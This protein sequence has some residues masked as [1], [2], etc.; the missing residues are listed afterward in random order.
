MAKQKSKLLT[1]LSKLVISSQEA[2]S[3]GKQLTALEKYLHVDRKIQIDLINQMGK[4]SKEG[5]KHLIFLTGSSGDGKS[6]LFSIIDKKQ[7]ELS[8]KFL[9][10]YD[11]TA[12][13]RPDLNSIETLIKDLDSFSDEKINTYSNDNSFVILAINLGVLN[14]FISNR[15]V[16]KK[17]SELIKFVDN[18]K[19]YS[20]GKITRVIESNEN[21]LFSI[22]NFTGYNDLEFKDD[23]DLIESQ[24]YNNIFKKI[25]NTTQSNPFYKAYLYDKE[26]VDTTQSRILCTNFEMLSTPMIQA[27]I[28]NLI[29]MARV[30]NKTILT[31]RLLFDFIYRIL[32]PSNINDDNLKEYEVSEYLPYLLFE[33]TGKGRLDEP[34]QDLD[35][36]GFRNNKIDK[37]I[38]QFY[39]TNLKNYAEETKKYPFG[40]VFE[41]T[42]KYITNSKKRSEYCAFYIRV[43]WLLGELDIPEYFE[44]YYDYCKFLKGYYNNDRDVLS[45]IISL[46]RSAFFSWF[47]DGKDIVYIGSQKENMKLGY[48]L[49]IQVNTESLNNNRAEENQ[50]FLFDMP[51][52]F[53]I[54]QHKDKK[55]KIELN[56]SLINLLKRVVNDNYKPSIIDE[57]NFLPFVIF[58]KQLIKLGQNEES[59][60]FIINNKSN[61]KFSLTEDFDLGETFTFTKM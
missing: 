46:I 44:D 5:N 17:Y 25:T 23:D 14:N 34:L 58:G 51:L 42:S 9:K 7:P 12:S 59:E 24:F 32:V 22:I 8:N 53:C 54:K 49:R 19:I 37:I 11:A 61:S 1:E 36:L 33:P 4:V 2:T 30:Q 21:K 3:N 48:K 57:D 56:Y 55:E 26:H 16:K 20:D 13:S 50:G 6:H 40:N 29:I 52:S 18:S 41:V 10:I 39:L 15:H 27:S 43:I 45:N 38:N 35:I 47:G 31:T 60:L 28:I